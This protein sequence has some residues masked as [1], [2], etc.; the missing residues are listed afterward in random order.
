MAES[1]AEAGEM[2]RAKADSSQLRSH[3]LDFSLSAMESPPDIVFNLK[4]LDVDTGLKNDQDDK[5]SKV[6]VLF[7]IFSPKK[8]KKKWN[9]VVNK[10]VLYTRVGAENK[11]QTRTW[12]FQETHFA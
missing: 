10:G 7:G 3:I 6:C 4:H 8:E 1:K 5:G 2:G 12:I 11:L 9:S